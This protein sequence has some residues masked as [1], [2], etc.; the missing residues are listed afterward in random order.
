VDVEMSGG[1]LVEQA[2]HHLDAMSWAMKDQ[3]P[4]KCV[5]MGY[6]QVDD[7]NG[8]KIQTEDHSATAFEFPGGV[9]F[10][11]TQ[12][13]RLPQ[14]FTDEKLWVFCERAGI[15][16]ATGMQYGRKGDRKRVAPSSVRQWNEKTHKQMVRLAGRLAGGGERAQ[17]EFTDEVVKAAGKKDWNRGT[18]EE[19]L[20]FVD[21]I[22][23]GGKRT[24]SANVE[25]GRVSTLMAIMGRTAMYNS[26]KNAFDP[27]VIR[28]EDLGST[29]EPSA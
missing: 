27:R 19:L 1:E 11:Y 13:F 2:V 14:F 10:S 28:W 29:S 12:L 6:R 16:L 8:P 22:K 3:H 5:S 17:Q 23:T 4:L 25:T 20:D 24:P 26:A 21:N 7:P 15:D 9:I 18:T